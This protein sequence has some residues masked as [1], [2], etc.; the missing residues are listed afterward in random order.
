MRGRH[1]Y[2]SSHGRDGWWLASGHLTWVCKQVFRISEGQLDGLPS[3]HLSE[4]TT[5]WLGLSTGMWAS[6]GSHGSLLR[7]LG[8]VVCLSRFAP[9]L[10]PKVP[11]LAPWSRSHILL[12]VS[13]R[14]RVSIA[15]GQ[16]L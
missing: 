9:P 15:A 6:P 10:L 2:C 16:F 13:M 14:D 5:L 3:L 4:A 11:G 12:T 7:G 8:H 1:R